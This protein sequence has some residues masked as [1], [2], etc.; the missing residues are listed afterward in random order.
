M[1]DALIM[2]RAG[3]ADPRGDDLVAVRDGAGGATAVP[4]SGY[5]RRPAG[6]TTTARK[7]A[8]TSAGLV[9]V[10]RRGRWAGMTTVSPASTVCRWPSISTTAAPVSTVQTCSVSIACSGPDWPARMSTRHTACAAPPWVGEARVVMTALGVSVR[11]VSARRMTGIAY[12]R[13]L[14]NMVVEIVNQVVYRVK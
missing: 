6:A 3:L 5:A 14:D 4:S 7:S 13:N 1:R 2:E 12:S 8:G 10:I 11:R 9:A